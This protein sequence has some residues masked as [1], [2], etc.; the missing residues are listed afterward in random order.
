M[1]HFDEHEPSAC[2]VIILEVQP[3]GS[4]QNR[5]IVNSGANMSI[6]PEELKELEDKVASFDMVALQLE[7][8]MQI[9]ELIAEYAYKK[10]VPVMLNSAPY[11]PLSDSLLSHLSFISPNETE[12]EDLTGIA[13]RVDGKV[14]LTNAKCAAMQLRRKGVK[15]VLITLGS[16]G[17]LLLN[18][19]GCIHSPCATNISAV[20]PT[21]AGDS[22][23]GAFCYAVCCGRPWEEV[24]EFA[25]H[26]AALTVSAMGAMPSLPTLDKVNGMLK[27]RGKRSFS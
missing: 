24:L 12:A 4:T 3:D 9:N 1:I 2:S 15:N 23:V 16:A 7:I 8:P 13:I 5:I 19:D 14:D 20:D 18:D 21:A 26:C 11:A 27:S 22:F 17:A 10:G 25:N 6:R